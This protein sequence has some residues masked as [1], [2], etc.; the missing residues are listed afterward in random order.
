MLSAVSD[1]VKKF[2][3]VNADDPAT[4]TV[5][6]RD[7]KEHTL[8]K[9][10]LEI[11]PRWVNF[12]GAVPRSEAVVERDRLGMPTRWMANYI[13]SRAKTMNVVRIRDMMLGGYSA[14]LSLGMIGAN[15]ERTVAVIT[16]R[17]PMASV[18][19]TDGDEGMSAAVGH[20]GS[21]NNAEEQELTLGLS[22]KI[23]ETY[24]TV[25]EKAVL[26]VV[27]GKMSLVPLDITAFLPCPGISRHSENAV[28]LP[29]LYC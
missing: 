21:L 2:M 1:G 18:Q 11:V 24:G 20:G 4:A 15:I 23:M 8:A 25:I 22:V 26:N 29:P 14:S 13:L 10:P 3:G 27:T 12:S 19:S 17:S 6:K 5:K 16:A 9:M 28:P 7:K